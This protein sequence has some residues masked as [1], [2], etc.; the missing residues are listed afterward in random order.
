[1]TKAMRSLMIEGAGCLAVCAVLALFIAKFGEEG[2]YQDGLAHVA[3]AVGVILSAIF[4]PGLLAAAYLFRSFHDV[5]YS[6][7]FAGVCIELLMVWGI[8]RRRLLRDA[9]RS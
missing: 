3:N 1:M 6:T 7:Y 9:F 8:M 5:P 4:T 2:L